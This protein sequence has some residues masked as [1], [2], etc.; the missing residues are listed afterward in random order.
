M[1]CIPVGITSSAVV[2]KNCP[3]TAVISKY[4]SI[5]NKKKKNDKILFNTKVRKSNL[6]NSKIN[7]DPIE[8]LISNYLIDSYISHDE[9]FSVNNV[10]R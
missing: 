5:I 10:L 4:K 3:I 9:L 2:I 1:V 7:L 8:V 6:G